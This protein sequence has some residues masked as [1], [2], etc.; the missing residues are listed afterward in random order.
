[1]TQKDPSNSS[2]EPDIELLGPLSWRG[3][4]LLS[5]LSVGLDKTH[6]ITQIERNGLKHGTYGENTISDQVV[7]LEWNSLGTMCLIVFVS[8]RLGQGLKFCD[9]SRF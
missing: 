3:N 8:G 5:A 7:N 4:G 2:S 9:F 1:M 6:K